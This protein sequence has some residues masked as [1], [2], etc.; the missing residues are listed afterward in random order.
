MVVLVVGIPLAAITFLGTSTSD[1][2]V[3]V[4]RATAGSTTT[5]AADLS[6]TPAAMFT[7]PADPAQVIDTD[8]ALRVAEAFWP[9]H[10]AAI[11]AS[12]HA[13]LQATETGAALAYDKVA[14]VEGGCIDV[15][16]GTVGP[17]IV[18]APPQ[19]AYPA[20]F[21]AQLRERCTCPGDPEDTQFLQQWYVVFTRQSAEQPWL[22]TI[23]AGVEHVSQVI[24]PSTPLPAEVPQADADFAYLPDDFATFLEISK[25]TGAPP[26][27]STI[28]A[29][30]LAGGLASRLVGFDE[31]IARH[32]IETQTEYR[33]SAAE[34]GSFAFQAS[35]D[36]Q[37]VCSAVRWTTVITPANGGSSVRIDSAVPITALVP[38]GT[39]SRVVTA[40]VRQAC[41]L[42][43]TG[44]GRATVVGVNGGNVSAE[45]ER[46]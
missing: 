8:T 16:P 40:G 29:A 36:E 9:V 13:M 43:P 17:I 2:P 30:G 20:N 12:D 7:S 34:D 32:G 14:C 24:D 25:S 35:P 1:E 44:A 6:Q 19:F 41:F 26:M 33:S 11:R 46:S 3:A 21:V 22:A 27:D 15:A 45:V 5:I 18:T 39:Y 28:S 4:G 37:L 31:E 10:Q 38:R 42:V 23:I